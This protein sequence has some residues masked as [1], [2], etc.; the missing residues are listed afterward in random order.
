MRLTWISRSASPPSGPLAVGEDGRG[1]ER[2]GGQ[3]ISASA[4]ARSRCSGVCEYWWVR[5]DERSGKER[6]HA[7][8][9]YWERVWAEDREWAYRRRTGRSSEQQ[10]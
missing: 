5:R 1:R 2:V 3:T 9:L 7:E 6:S 8:Q 4:S 10:N